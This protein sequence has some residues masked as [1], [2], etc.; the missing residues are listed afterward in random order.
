MREGGAREQRGCC[1]HAHLQRVV[2]QQLLCVCSRRDRHPALC[3]GGGP[4]RL[5]A[6]VCHPFKRG[7]PEHGCG[8]KLHG[9]GS[10]KCDHERKAGRRARRVH[11]FG[12]RSRQPIHIA[13]AACIQGGHK[14]GVSTAG[15]RWDIASTC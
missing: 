10:L 2:S 13:R 15:S 8:V 12:E 9:E 3:G 6:V 14:E 7:A 11:L 1:A 4:S 5:A